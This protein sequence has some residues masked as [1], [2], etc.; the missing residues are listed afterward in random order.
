MIDIAGMKTPRIRRTSVCFLMAKEL[1]QIL[2]LQL[3]SLPGE[4][5]GCI[6]LLWKPRPPKAAADSG[7]PAAWMVTQPP[8]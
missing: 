5:E 6:S 1:C 2:P 3:Q 7:L 8:R 4:V